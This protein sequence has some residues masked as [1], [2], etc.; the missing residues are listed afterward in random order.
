MKLN[1]ANR[2]DS[3]GRSVALGTFDGVHRG[4]QELLQ[5]TIARKPAG[6]T[7][8]VLTFDI[9]PEQFFRGNLQLLSTFPRRTELFHVFGIDEVAWF[10]FGPD[11]ASMEA[12]HFV[13]RILVEEMKA[14]AVICGYDYRF[15]KGRAGDAEYL[16]EQGERLGFAVKI[17]PQVQGTGGYT[18]SSTRIRTLLQEGDLNQVR[19]CLGYYPTYQVTLASQTLQFDP[20]LVLP[21]KGLYLIWYQPKT[22]SGQAALGLKTTGH[23]MV[24]TFLHDQPHDR[25]ENELV[26]VGLLAKISE[27][28]SPE[29]TEA[30]VL[31]AKE[32][33]TSIC[34]Q[35]GRVMLK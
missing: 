19:E 2:Q 10:N 20:A 9:P 11:I 13:E 14:K 4:H 30:K 3:P 18:I 31:R 29:I 28:E 5:E 12:S 1:W 22:G 27:D 33:L 35:E 25:A 15:G 7:S 24:V 17:V 23:E 32:M 16:K 6:G 21:R 34:L 8:A 26:K